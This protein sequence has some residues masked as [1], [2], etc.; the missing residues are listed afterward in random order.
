MQFIAAISDIKDR[1]DAFVTDIWGVLHNGAKTYP[2]VIDCLRELRSCGKK[3]ILLSNSGRRAQVV[4]TDLCGFGITPELYT[5]VV[6]SGELTHLGFKTNVDVR[7]QHLGRSYY[8][9]GSERYGLTEGLGLHR[10]DD[11][12]T[13]EFILTIGVE[14][15]P[16]S[17]QIYEESLHYLVQR[18]LVMVCANPDVSVNRNGVLGIGPGAL[19]VYYEHLGGRVIYFGKPFKAV[20]NLCLEKLYG[21]ADDRIV[22]VG[23]S[24]KTDIA[25]ANHCGIDNILIG[26]GIHYQELATIPADVQQIT[27]L[28]R[29]EDIFPTMIANGF[30]W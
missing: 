19:G 14:G 15:N 21:I 20:Y 10:T 9:F 28:C 5:S 1:Y 6:T 24:L 18:G 7:L 17:T 2:G 30:V 27:S 23:D 11:P 8:L 16:R 22:I 29:A 25:G 12:A 4:S 13:A 26:T 3:V